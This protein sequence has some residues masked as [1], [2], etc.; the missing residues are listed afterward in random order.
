[1]GI[2]IQFAG[3][4]HYRLRTLQQLCRSIPK[5]AAHRMIRGPRRPGWNMF[6]E[7]ATDFLKRRLIDAFTMADV[8]SARAYLDSVVISSPA[9]ARVCFTDVV[10]ESFRGTWVAQSAAGG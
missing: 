4:F 9:C 10:E 5:V 1:M 2:R 6:V 7:A 8:E 3:P